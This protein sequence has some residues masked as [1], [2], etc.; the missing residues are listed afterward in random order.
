MSQ[1]MR[2]V[3]FQPIAFISAHNGAVL[4]FVRNIYFGA[5]SKFDKPNLMG[6]G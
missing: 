5:K 3:Y 4:R 6:E 1:E 2:D